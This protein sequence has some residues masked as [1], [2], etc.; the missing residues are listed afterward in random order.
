LDVVQIVVTRWVK[1]D[2]T[3]DKQ[4]GPYLYNTPA[5]SDR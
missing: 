1:L 5:F 4:K 3:G 2:T